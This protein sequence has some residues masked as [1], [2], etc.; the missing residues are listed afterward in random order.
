MILNPQ[1]RI[2]LTKYTNYEQLSI[3]N[4]KNLIMLKDLYTSVIFF[5]T[6]TI[7]KKCTQFVKMMKEYKLI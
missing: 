7:T 4:S 2:K 3:I 1:K 6:P 5:A